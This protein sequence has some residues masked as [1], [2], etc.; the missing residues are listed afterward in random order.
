VCLFAS[1]ISNR[2]YSQHSFNNFLLIIALSLLQNVKD[3]LTE[4]SE[5]PEGTINDDEDEI[6]ENASKI[7]ERINNVNS[8]FFSIFTLSASFILDY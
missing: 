6:F 7:T 1:N 3:A 5:R 4:A 8:I 2:Q